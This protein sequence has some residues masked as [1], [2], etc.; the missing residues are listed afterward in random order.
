LTSCGVQTDEFT[1]ETWKVLLDDLDAKDFEKSVIELLKNKPSFYSTDNIPGLIREGAHT[2][3]RERIKLLEEKKRR[4]ALPEK[5]CG[6][7]E[8]QENLKKIKELL[9]HF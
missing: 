7:E 6:K 1:I 2:A 9:D 5:R 4:E 3:R 8:A